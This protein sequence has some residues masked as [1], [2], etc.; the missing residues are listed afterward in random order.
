MQS[1]VHAEL[2]ASLGMGI[3]S[4]GCTFYKLIHKMSAAIIHIHIS[5]V[6]QNPT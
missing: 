4:T 1:F 6:I 2:K 3:N 5:K